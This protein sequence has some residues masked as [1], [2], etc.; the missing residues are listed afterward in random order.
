MFPFFRRFK[1]IYI[2]DPKLWYYSRTLMERFTWAKRKTMWSL[3][4]EGHPNCITGSIVT[5]FLLNGWILRIGGASAVEGL[6]STG[7]PRLVLKINIFLLVTAN[8]FEIYMHKLEN[9]CLL[10]FLHVLIHVVR[11]FCIDLCIFLHQIFRHEILPAQVWE[12]VE[13]IQQIQ[14]INCI[15]ILV[16][17]YLVFTTKISLE[18]KRLQKFEVRVDY[19]CIRCLW[20]REAP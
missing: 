12:E 15:A 11:S 14:N 19:K 5:A 20:V 16:I 4:H 13:H 9:S 10:L 6:Q 17:Y 3:N 2:F 8:H 18:V 7:V 1:I